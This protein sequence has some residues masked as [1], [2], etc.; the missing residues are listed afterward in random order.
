V[1]IGDDVYLENEYPECVEIGNGVTLG[2][3]SIVVAHGMGGP[4]RIVI[5]DNAFIGCNSLL[6]TLRNRT[7]TIGQGSVVMAGSV[8]T[9][10]VPRFTSVGPSPARAN[11]SLA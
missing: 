3:R 11:P 5:E 10:D 6:I 4:G 8:V 1:F 7:L 2:L 9:M